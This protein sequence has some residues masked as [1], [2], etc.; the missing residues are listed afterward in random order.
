MQ[1]NLAQFV[2]PLLTIPC[3]AREALW[4]YGNKY[5]RPLE[6]EQQRAEGLCNRGQLADLLRVQDDLPLQQQ[7]GEDLHH[8]QYTQAR[9]QQSQPVGPRTLRQLR[10]RGQRLREGLGAFGHLTAHHTRPAQQP[11]N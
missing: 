3:H 7:V 10:S 9:H 4:Q 11:M 1:R 5:T 8:S 6:G 2:W